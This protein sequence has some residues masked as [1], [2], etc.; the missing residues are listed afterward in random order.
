MAASPTKYWEKKVAVVTGAGKGIGRAIAIELFQKGCQLLVCVSRS[1]EDL[2]DFKK[3]CVQHGKNE[4]LPDL[5][6]VLGDLEDD[7][8]AVFACVTKQIETKLQGPARVDY[9]INN[10][11]VALNEPVLD[12]KE[13]NWR[14][15]MNINCLAA[16]IG[17][18]WFG[19]LK[20]KSNETGGAIVNLSS[21]AS[22]IALQD[23]ASYC[24]SKAAMDALTRQVALELGSQFGTRCNSVC[25]TVV[26]TRMGRE[27]WENGSEKGKK[28]KDK[29]PLGRFCEEVDV[30]NVVLFLLTEEFSG[31][32]NG[33]CLPV[34]GGFLAGCKM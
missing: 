5:A 13:E 31:M 11:G 4:K 2:D 8:T 27:N 16:A 3:E 1:V 6:C 17:C 26:L 24:M 10:A 20:S 25:P 12:L 21:Q 14:K 34:E 19:N 30:V 18:K 22:S 29:I 28:M 32:M 9:L 7:P 23:H 33:A 15:T